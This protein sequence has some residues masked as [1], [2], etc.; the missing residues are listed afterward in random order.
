[1]AMHQILMANGVP[2][3]NNRGNSI[4]LARLMD[5][6]IQKTYDELI[7]LADT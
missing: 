4:S 7:V 6:M 1:M 2:Q 5:F 3:D